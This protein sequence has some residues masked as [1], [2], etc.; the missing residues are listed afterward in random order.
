VNKISHLV[1]QLLCLTT[2]TT[3]TSLQL[4]HILY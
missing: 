3:T 1:M 2:Y 4:L